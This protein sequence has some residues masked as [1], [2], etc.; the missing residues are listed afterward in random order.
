MTPAYPVIKLKE[1]FAAGAIKLIP[2]QT[3]PPITAAKMSAGELNSLTKKVSLFLT[4]LIIK[5]R[6]RVGGT[7]K[8]MKTS[9]EDKSDRDNNPFGYRGDGVP[10]MARS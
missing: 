10:R 7:A 5:G 8:S 2:R 4:S 1:V 3:A 9:L 6:F